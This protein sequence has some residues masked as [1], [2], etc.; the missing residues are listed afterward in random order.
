MDTVKQSGTFTTDGGLR[1]S[2]RRVDR[3]VAMESSDEVVAYLESVNFDL[4]AVLDA[5]GTGSVYNAEELFG[6]AVSKPSGAIWVRF[7]HAA[8][9][10]LDSRGAFGIYTGFIRTADR[11]PARMRSVGLPFFTSSAPL[12]KLGRLFVPRVPPSHDHLI[13]AALKQIEDAG[14][15][16]VRV[17]TGFAYW[18]GSD[19]PWVKVDGI[20]ED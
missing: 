3:I 12:W 4:G 2:A 18:P 10:H 17:G 19:Q 20:S 16:W 8:S 9:K 7:V 6:R 1:G 15:T 11:F 14:W 13:A 5:V